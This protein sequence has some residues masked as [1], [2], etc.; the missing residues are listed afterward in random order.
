[1]SEKI[2]ET[3]IDEA[4]QALKSLL[5]D[6]KCRLISEKEPTGISVIQGSLW[7]TSP[8]TAQKKINFTLTQEKSNI[9]IIG[10]S[11]LTP[12]Y[13]NFTVIGYVL[14]ILL[15]V[16]FLW[17]SLDLRLYASTGSA[18]IWSWLGQTSGI[19]DIDKI[20]IFSRITEIFTAFLVAT[21]I[22]ESAIIW[23][24]N[25]KIHYFAEKKLDSLTVTLQ[26]RF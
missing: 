6:S 19:M 16:I 4:Y 22:F 13:K 7:G 26:N 2:F 1:M 10:K 11:A 24:I 17:I 8:E 5:T 18:G 12:S 15:I 14:S 25:R 20:A 9:K 3:K 23:N 21:M